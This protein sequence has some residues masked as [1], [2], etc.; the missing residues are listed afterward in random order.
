MSHPSCLRTTSSPPPRVATGRCG[1]RRWRPCCAAA[2]SATA[3]GSWWSARRPGP[4]SA[5]TLP[6]A[7]TLQWLR[8]AR[9]GAIRA[10]APPPH[11]SSLEARLRFVDDLTASARR[12]AD[13]LLADPD[14]VALLREEG[15]RLERRIAG[16]AERDELLL[17][18]RSLKRSLY[19]YQ[20]EGVRRFFEEERLLLADDMGLGKTTQAVAACHALFR[21]GRVARGLLIVPAALKPQ[22]VREWQATTDAPIAHRRRAPGGAAAPVRGRG[23][24]ASWSSA[25]S[26]SCATS[27]PCTRSIPEVV[28]L[29][30]AQRIKNWETKSAAYVKTLRARYRLVLT[31]TPMENRLEELASVLDWVDDIALAPKWRLPA[32]AHLRRRRRRARARPARGT[33]TRCASDC[34]PCWCAASARRS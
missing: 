18:L 4:R 28:V 6:G 7:A 24:A 19:P 25:T 23:C 13:G 14:A 20:R 15:E 33:S 27:A 26:S 34:S 8:L 30:E 17:H 22:W 10:S 11:L 31:G 1:G 12:G 3:T 29:D 32:V 9:G 5:A 16:R 21:A 2:S